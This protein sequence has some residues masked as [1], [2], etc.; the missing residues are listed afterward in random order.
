MGQQIFAKYF[1]RIDRIHYSVAK[2]HFGSSLI[3]L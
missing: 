2:P 3:K 1:I